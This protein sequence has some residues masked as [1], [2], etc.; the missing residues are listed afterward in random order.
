MR[1]GDLSMPSTGV[2]NTVLFRRLPHGERDF[3]F[4]F[5]DSDIPMLEKKL[6]DYAASPKV[7]FDEL[8]ARTVMTAIVF[9]L[10]RELETGRRIPM[11]DEVTLNEDDGMID[12]KQHVGPGELTSTR[13]DFLIEL[14]LLSR[15][16]NNLNPH[17]PNGIKLDS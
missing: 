1:L 5:Q 16:L 17:K 6:E 3:I 12:I 2:Q 14:D 4:R 9:H 15:R 7:P 10:Q 13:P 8:D 11:K